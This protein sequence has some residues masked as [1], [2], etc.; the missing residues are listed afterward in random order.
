MI[1][2]SVCVGTSCHLNGANNVVM[3]FQ[4]LIEEYKLHDKISFCAS[5]CAQAC[6]K[7]TVSV[8][9]NDEKFAI[10]ASEAR[11]FFKEKIL[12]LVK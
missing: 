2:L 1:N 3:S 9:V 11:A 5:F 8:K 6:S 7:D 4:Y 10:H 12:P